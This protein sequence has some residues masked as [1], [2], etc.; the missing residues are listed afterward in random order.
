MQCQSLAKKITDGDILNLNLNSLLP[1]VQ[2]QCS[3]Y[4]FPR[5]SHLAISISH[6]AISNKH[7]AFSNK[8]FAISI[9]HLAISISHLAISNKHLAIS[10]KHFAFFIIGIGGQ[11]LNPMIQISQNAKRISHYALRISHVPPGFP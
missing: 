1:L 5:I 7:S 8:H 2:I 9:S 10:N 3:D 4:I 11:L 6:L